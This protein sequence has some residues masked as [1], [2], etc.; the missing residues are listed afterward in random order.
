MNI[1]N[2]VTAQRIGSDHPPHDAS[3]DIWVTWFWNDFLPDW[4]DRAIDRDG[5]GLFDVLDANANPVMPERR[6][7][8]A[9]ARLL[10]TFSHLALMSDTPAYHKAARI[11]RDALPFFKK[12]SGLYRR[13]VTAKGAPSDN[14]ADNEAH[15]YDQSF[16]LLGLATWGKLNPDED[17]SGDLDALWSAVEQQLTDP[18]TG[19]MLEHDALVDPR[20][21]DAPP[22]AQNPHMHLYE[23]ALQA[24]AMTENPVWLDRAAHMRAKGIEYFFDTDSG[25]I[26][27]FLTHD[28]RV[29][30]G[31]DGMR[32]EVGHQCE[33]AWL[34][35][36]EVALGGDPSVADIAARLLAFADLHGFATGGPMAGAAYDAVAADAAWVEDRFLMWPQTEAIKAMVTRPDADRFRPQ[37]QAIGQLIFQKYF[38]GHAAYVNQIDGTGQ[39]IW[40]EALSRLHYHLVLALT[41][42]ADA[43]LWPAP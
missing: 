6:T 10:F 36:R 2:A 35:R 12:P 25:T 28:L 32:R 9:Q 23:A 41:E 7:I 16:V 27:E 42:G 30:P 24:Y 31:R 11:A 34:L 15:S 29:Q 39:V 33:W 8:L 5:I 20:A 17:V 40:P 18:A 1:E 19:M 4:V 14:S 37:V 13:A 43:G 3:V 38:A 22:R 21:A 26:T